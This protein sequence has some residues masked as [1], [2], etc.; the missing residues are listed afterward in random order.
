MAAKQ[1]SFMRT[2]TPVSARL[3]LRRV[4]AAE[5]GAAGFCTIITDTAAETKLAEALRESQHDL[6][7]L[8]SEVMAAEENERKRIA[9]D[10]HDG[11]GQTLGALK[12]GMENAISSL[13]ADA[14]DDARGT[15]K[16]LA[17]K[18]REALDEVRRMAMNL[19]PA[20]L[21]DLGI[22]AT[23]SWF[24]RDFQ[25][26]YRTIEVDADLRI[27]EADVPDALKVT[28]FRIVQE[29]L[30]NVARH[31]RATHVRLSVEKSDDISAAGYCRQWRWLRS[32]RGSVAQTVS[33]G[34]TDT[35][36]C[37]IASTSVTAR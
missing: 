22:V 16:A 33:T 18:V 10:L 9:A 35:R 17:P 28:M 29:A 34:G 23:L 8:S 26:I 11:L 13:D 25:T 31:S 6:V 27:V 32:E 36:A 3:R 21:D 24:V 20:T 5:V 4:D 2:A 15:L 30:N 19:R 1:R 12:F 7:C 14:V 37:A